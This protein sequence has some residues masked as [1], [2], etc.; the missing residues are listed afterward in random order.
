M[1]NDDSDDLEDYNLQ[2][3]IERSLGIT[4]TALVKDP[5]ISGNIPL[6]NQLCESLGD[7]PST[8][9]NG[10]GKTVG[11]YWDAAKRGRNH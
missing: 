11:Q 7:K 8:I 6:K 1:S 2:A 4:A 9:I 5:M 3:T 10:T